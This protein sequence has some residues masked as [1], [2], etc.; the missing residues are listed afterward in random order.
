MISSKRCER[1]R[2]ATRRTE[3]EI[4]VTEPGDRTP[5]QRF[6]VPMVIWDAYEGLTKR[7][8]TNRSERLLDHIRAD[9]EKYGTEEERAALREGNA[10]LEKRRARKGGRPK[11]S[12][13]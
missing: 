7:L 1:I 8:G 9:I 10:E 6:R 5:M 12:Q 4:E 11:R 13:R 3:V 2:V